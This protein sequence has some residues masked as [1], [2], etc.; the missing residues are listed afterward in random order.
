MPTPA[1]LAR[2]TRGSEASHCRPPQLRCEP[3]CIA[4]PTTARRRPPGPASNEVATCRVRR[5][6]RRPPS[7]L[8]DMRHTQAPG[9][10][11]QP[12]TPPTPPTPTPTAQAPSSPP[13][14]HRCVVPLTHPRHPQRRRHEPRA[15]GENHRFVGLRGSPLHP[16]APPPA[17]GGGG[18]CR[19][20]RGRQQR[21]WRQTRQSGRGARL[22]CRPSGGVW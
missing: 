19:T 9:A 6:N 5:L 20:R 10:R 11:Q 15:P 14:L 12:L 16:H 3:S 17:R 7:Q 21:R 18:A 1:P 4:P 22:E 2:V 13:P 8:N